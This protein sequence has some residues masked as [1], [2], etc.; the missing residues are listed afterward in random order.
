MSKVVMSRC[1]PDSAVLREAEVD[2]TVARV[3]PAG[4]D[5]LAAGEEVHT[6]GAVGVGVAEQRALPAA[7]A[8]VRG[9]HR[10]RH[11]DADH[12]DLDAGYTEEQVSKIKTDLVAEVTPIVTSQGQAGKYTPDQCNPVLHNVLVLP[13]SSS[14]AASET[15]APVSSSAPDSSSSAQ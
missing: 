12:A 14:S 7:E 3:E 5:H 1:L 9:G 4:G 11:V 13:A 10:D 15:P 2:A 6:L 8:V